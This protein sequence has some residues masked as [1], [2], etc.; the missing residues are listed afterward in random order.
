VIP[1][2]RYTLSTLLQLLWGGK[3]GI[4]LLVG[5][6]AGGATAYVS[7]LP[8]MYRSVATI[9]VLPQLVPQNYVKSTVSQD[10]EDRLRP[11][12][13]RVLAPDQL[14]SICSD[15]Q[16]YPSLST[17]EAG[18]Q[19]RSRISV[20]VL[21]SDAF[22]VGFIHLDPVLAAK[23][24]DRVAKAFVEEN[25][26]TRTGLAE[27][28]DQFMEEQL[29][30]TRARLTEHEQKLEEYRRLHAGELPS[31]LPANLQVIQNAQ[32]QLR[33]VADA[34]QQDRDRRLKVEETIASLTAAEERAPAPEEP[35][36]V[37]ADGND[38]NPDPL[39][40]DKLLQLRGRQALQQL[41]RI[42]ATLAGLQLEL[43][44]DHP[45]IVRL[46]R[47][48][49]SLE[50][51]VVADL[52]P[53]ALDTDNSPDAARDKL[54]AQQRAK[55]LEQLRSDLTAID[56]RLADRHAEETRIRQVAERYQQRIETSPTRETE[57]TTLMRDYDT[58]RESYRGLLAKKQEAQMAADLERRKVGETFTIVGPPSVPDRPFSPNRRAFVLEGAA[59][60]LAIGL[61][62]TAWR[63]YRD[64]TLRT[65][66]EIV[67]GLEL[68]VIGFIPVIVTAREEQ[69]VRLHR[70][71]WLTSAAGFFVGAGALWYFRMK[72]RL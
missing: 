54:R 14:A 20:N 25:Q 43:K 2:R 58:L 38:A 60:G 40:N 36:P 70:F 57:L 26:R 31:Q 63:E 52:G 41:P 46:K 3:L 51:R 44:P 49:A 6:T 23:V 13:D 67:N 4:L 65:E 35:D 5:I 10:L 55:S 9:M 71:V 48:V 12:S 64:C 61:I 18:Q 33:A 29:Q 16:V 62:V 68:P 69:L 34:I 24:T 21:R 32:V 50:R 39:V 15:L 22:L 42:R 11:M 1:G 59:V 28:T 17:A 53:G 56:K 7:R 19:L 27:G 30:T 45:D 47:L 37:A 66:S 72:G 8:N